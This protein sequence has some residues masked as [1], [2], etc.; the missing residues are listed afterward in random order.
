MILKS[1]GYLSTDLSSDYAGGMW[2]YIGREK[3]PSS[4]VNV[5]AIEAIRYK[6]VDKI[7]NEILEEIEESKAFFQ[8]YDGAVYMNQGKTFLV[9]HL[10]LS[11]RIAWCQE[12]DVNY[13]TKTRD[14]TVIHVIG[15]HIAYPARIN[16]DQ[17]THTTAQKH[18]CKVTT[19]WFG[20][21]RIW[22]R[23][24]QVL[25]TVELSLPDYT[26]ESQTAVEASQY[27]FRGGLHAAGHAILNVVPLYIICNQSDIASEC[28]NPHDNHYVPERIL[29]YDPHP[30]GTG[31]SAKV[32]P[33]FL[34]LLS[35]ALELL[36]SCH[37]SG[38]AGCPN[39]VQN[40]ACHEYNEVL[41]K[42]AAI[43]I[44]EV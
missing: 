4:S 22:R 26:Y 9:K 10:D 37:C 36:S 35:S 41:H 21:R 19:T 40:L 5:R 31:I 29:L 32:Q 2:A 17:F 24:N 3:S 16:N 38:D 12:A 14:F 15:S 7:K 13:Y 27:S 33:L 6:V 30:G 34:E 43:M 11:S 44:I 39:C 18:V 28:A 8:V 42:D 20:F 25:D 1:K 23:S